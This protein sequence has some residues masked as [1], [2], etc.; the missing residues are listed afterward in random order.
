MHPN[1][2]PQTNHS[3]LDGGAAAVSAAA[4]ALVALCLSP[5]EPVWT[6]EMYALLRQFLKS[7]SVTRA[8]PGMAWLPWTHRCGHTVKERR[9]F[10]GRL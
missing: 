5:L 9:V 6:Y 8:E 7:I 4:L 10:V 2:C 1:N 3:I